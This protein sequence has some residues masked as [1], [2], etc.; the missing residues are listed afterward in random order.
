[1]AF[2]K[3]LQ[4]KKN[5]DRNLNAWQLVRQFNVYKMGKENMV[6]QQLIIQNWYFIATD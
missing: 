5:I 6:L 4:W 2:I 3:T 1:M